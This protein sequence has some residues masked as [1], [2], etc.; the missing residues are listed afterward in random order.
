MVK[1]IYVYDHNVIPHH[2]LFDNDIIL[3]VYEFHVSFICD[4]IY[5]T[6]YD[7]NPKLLRLTKVASSQ[8][9]GMNKENRL[10]DFPQNVGLIL[11]V[12]HIAGKVV[13]MYCI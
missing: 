7:F 13:L 3:I 4:G 6:R 1:Y 9:N 12:Y 10:T 8:L 11:T 5:V 2:I